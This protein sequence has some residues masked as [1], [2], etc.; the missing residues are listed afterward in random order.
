MDK[1]EA[2]KVDQ[3]SA[4]HEFERFCTLFDLDTDK[5]GMDEEDLESLKD[6]ERKFTRLVSVGRLVVED[7]PPPSATMRL[8][9]GDDLVFRE[10]EGKH[11]LAMDTRKEGHKMAKLHAVAASLTG[12]DISYFAKVPLRDM[13]YVYAVVGLLVGG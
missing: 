12:K 2:R 6:A 9:S 11:L 7:G 8:T 10:P 13:K 3:E 5:E 1:Q 4:K